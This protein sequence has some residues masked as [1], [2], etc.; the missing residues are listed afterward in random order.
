MVDDMVEW[1]RTMIAA[2]ACA[3]LCG[4]FAANAEAGV[5]VLGNGYAAQ[6]F[7]MAIM[8]TRNKPELNA[9]IKNCDNA[10]EFD[11]LSKRDRAATLVNRGIL[12]LEKTAY[13]DA[14]ADFDKAI[15]LAPDLPEA[16]VN[17]GAALLGLRRFAEALV[18]LNRGIEMNSDEI[19][20]AYYNRGLAREQLNDVKGAYYD[21]LKASELR[22]AWEPPLRELKRFTVTRP[23]RPA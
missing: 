15:S 22:P 2:F 5:T 1:I 7:R 16:Y 19:E 17:R 23:A 4:W 3:G 18:D 13:G 21:Y 14:R 6:C 20:K 11:F 9:S 10:L 8:S 12:L